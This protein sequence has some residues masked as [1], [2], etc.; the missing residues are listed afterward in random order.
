M[1]IFINLDKISY[2]EIIFS[3][4]QKDPLTGYL[5]FCDALW[6]TI[7]PNSK[8]SMQANFPYLLYYKQKNCVILQM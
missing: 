5:G 7:L 6:V 2:F 8:F 4:I 1:S 3:T